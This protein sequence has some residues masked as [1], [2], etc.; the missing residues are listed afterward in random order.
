M[1][2]VSAKHI[3]V[4]D[5]STAQE[6]LTKI[7]AGE[8]FEELAKSHSKCPS[9]RDGGNLGSF[10]KGAMVPKFEEAAFA[11]SVGEVSGPIQ[12][13]FGYHLIQRSE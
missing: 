4:S 8:S 10:G 9:G 11:L 1:D 6:L 3:L 5:E 13:Q 12:T 2:T 7:Q